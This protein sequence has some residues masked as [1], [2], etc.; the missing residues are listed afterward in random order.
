MF[1]ELSAI[2]CS[3]A[4]CAPALRTGIRG[5]PRGFSPRDGLMTAVVKA[6]GLG[7]HKLYLI[8]SCYG[9]D[10]HFAED[11]RRFIVGIRKD[12][13]RLHVSAPPSPRFLGQNLGVPE[14]LFIY[15][16]RCL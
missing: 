4:T 13:G 5:V 10:V 1:V 14:D 3:P 16:V 6:T 8:R 9:H 15:S 7:L 2:S 12:K 11:L